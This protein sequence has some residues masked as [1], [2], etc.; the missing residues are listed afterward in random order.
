LTPVCA[1]LCCAVLC[2]VL[3]CPV[4]ACAQEF[5]EEHQLR[6]SLAARKIKV[7]VADAWE[8]SEAKKRQLKLE[9]LERD[10][11]ALLGG[12]MGGHACVHVCTPGAAIR[13]TCMRVLCPSLCN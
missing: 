12:A 10:G 5:E 1:V 7:D 6:L 2:C 13:W 8:R 4:S 3:C 9:L 11:K